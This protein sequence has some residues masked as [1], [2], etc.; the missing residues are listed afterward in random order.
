MRF[1]FGAR[2]ECDYTSC[3]CEENVYK[4]CERVPVDQRSRFFAVFV[5]NASKCVPLFA[6]KA[7]KERP[8][9]LWDYH[10]VLVEVRDV[11]ESLV[12]DLDTILEFPCTFDHYWIA[13]VQPEGWNI[14]PEYKRFFRVIPC[15]EFLSNFSSDRSHMI[16]ENGSWMAPPP[17]W[18]KIYKNGLN[19]IHDFICMDPNI[20]SE[21]STVLDENEM[22]LK[23]SNH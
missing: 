13:T 23:F 8:F 16:A 17:Q 14:A 15:A 2:E 22:M 4:L 9:V 11:E 20:L 1:S 18:E 10:V 21:I 19:N 5:S 12:W 6:Q 7:A 3:Y